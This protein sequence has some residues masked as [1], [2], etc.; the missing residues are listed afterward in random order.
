M[1]GDGTTATYKF[2]I[3]PDL[4]TEAPGGEPPTGAV[5]A[6]NSDSSGL[7]LAATA[8]ISTVSTDHFCTVTFNHNIPVSDPVNGPFIQ[9]Q[10]TFEY[11]SA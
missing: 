10:V 9:A 4:L 2:L 6:I 8:V 1:M 3:S 7:G 5:V 11:A